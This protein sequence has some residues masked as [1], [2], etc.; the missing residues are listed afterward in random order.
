MKQAFF[1]FVL[2]GAV[3]LGALGCSAPANDPAE[4]KNITNQKS[5]NPDAPDAPSEMADSP[6]ALKGQGPAGTKPPGP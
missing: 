1:G 2:A 3:V 6:K 5:Q 4:I